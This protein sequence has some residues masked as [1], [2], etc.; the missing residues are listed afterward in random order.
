M[1]EWSVRVVRK[2][3]GVVSSSD[4]KGCVSGKF[5]WRDGASE[6]WGAMVLTAASSNGHSG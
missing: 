2:G 5:E 1:S 4:E 6:Y 3:R